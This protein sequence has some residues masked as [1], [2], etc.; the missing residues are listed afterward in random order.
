[1]VRHWTGPGSGVPDD[2]GRRAKTRVVS[3]H[4]LN[5]RV[6]RHA[7]SRDHRVRIASDVTGQPNQSRVSVSNALLGSPG[8]T[9]RW[10]LLPSGAGRCCH[11][12]MC[13]VG[14]AELRLC[15]ALLLGQEPFELVAQF[16][17]GWHSVDAFGQKAASAGAFGEPVVLLLQCAYHVADLV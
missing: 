14:I 10:W 13:A 9:V 16:F 12:Q 4:G 2:R 3:I 5:V 1:M 8:G 15:V 7:S 6:D 17:G 11:R